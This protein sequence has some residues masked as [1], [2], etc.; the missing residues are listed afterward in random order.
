MT[1]YRK[2]NY[3][4]IYED[5]HGP[6]PKDTDGR[7]YEIHHIDGNKK[8]NN[9]DNLVALSIQEHYDV[10]YSQHDWGA[11]QRIAQRMGTP[12]EKIGELS[13]KLQLQRSLNGTHHFLGGKIQ[14]ET[15]ERQVR[16][17]R[18]AWQNS[19]HQR[20]LALQRKALGTLPGQVAAKDGTHNFLGGETQ[21]RMHQR[22]LENG[23]HHSQ[24]K[25]ECP[26]CNREGLGKSNYTRYHGDRCKLNG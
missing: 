16:E 24:V 8:N 25:W 22:H 3:R 11:C 13:S 17:G 18:H 7:T 9:P 26:H 5:Y 6:I 20:E 2:S 4:K 23:T 12:A 10:H 19:N 21:R 14:R 1:I 15:A